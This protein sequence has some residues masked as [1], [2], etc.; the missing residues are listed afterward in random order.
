MDDNKAQPDE[1]TFPVSDFGGWILYDDDLYDMKQEKPLTIGGF[2]IDG[3]FHEIKPSWWRNLLAK[4]RL[5]LSG[6]KFRQVGYD[7]FRRVVDD[8][9]KGHWESTPATHSRA[10]IKDWIRRLKR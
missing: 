7:E 2:F 6:W 4:I 3:R 1:E 5:K 8:T 9:G 10:S